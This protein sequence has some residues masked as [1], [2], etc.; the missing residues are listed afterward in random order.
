MVAIWNFISTGLPIQQVGGVPAENLLPNGNSSHGATVP[1]TGD[2]H[3]AGQQRGHA[4]LRPDQDLDTHLAVFDAPSSIYHINTRLRDGRQ[5]IILD[6]G[7]VGNLAGDKW[8]KEVAIEAS[9]HGFTP[10][11]EKRRRP[12]NVSGVGNGSQECVYDCELPVSLKN[13]DRDGVTTGKI[14]TPTVSGSDLPGLLGLQALK[15]NRTVM[16]LNT[17]KIYFLGPGDYDLLRAMPPGTDCYQA[18][19]APSGHL[20]LPICEY[21]SPKNSTIP[22]HSLTLVH[23]ATTSTPSVPAGVPPPPQHP[24][25]LPP[26]LDNGRSSTDGPLP[27]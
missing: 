22:E 2:P 26:S 16:D 23:D 12:L 17:N 5:S 18:T 21:L 19:E 14:T 13:H 4:H 8:C 15:R 20:V 1:A 6:P 9:K 24:P 7:S 3:Q 27:Q 25:V 11:Y 10:R